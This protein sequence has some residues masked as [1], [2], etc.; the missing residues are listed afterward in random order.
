M[1]DACDHPIPPPPGV[2][3]ADTFISSA[4]AEALNHKGN[5]VSY[6]C[7]PGSTVPV[8]KVFTKSEALASIIP[9]NE[10]NSIQSQGLRTKLLWTFFAS[11]YAEMV[12]TLQNEKY[13][14]VHLHTSAPLLEFSFLSL[15]DIPALITIHAS[16]GTLYENRVLES[17][18]KRDSIY[19]TSI[20]HYQEK[21]YSSLKFLRRIQHGI[22]LSEFP[23]NPQ[24][25]TDLL[26]AGRLK[27]IKGISEAVTTALALKQKLHIVGAVSYDDIPF[28]NAEIKPQI[29][30]HSD[31]LL[32]HGHKSRSEMNIFFGNA[33]LYLMPML[34]EEA[35]G[36]VLIESMACG[37][38]VVAF[39]RGSAQ[40]IVIDGKTGFLINPSDNDI[41]GNFIIKETGV[42]GLQEAVRRIN[43]LSQEDYLQ[44]RQN[45]RNHVE[46]YFTFDRMVEEYEE[47][48]KT[49]TSG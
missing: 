38:P 15:V 4:L 8:K 25:G 13:D 21:V 32:F 39:A 47:A 18:P 45:C 16:D 41:R 14:L 40:E 20:S 27:K 35:F 23:F 33:R 12:K 6:L 17:L 46:K 28:F 36:L 5:D 22:H 10:Y 37:T 2:I 34:W 11:T 24:G 43:T 9:L 29:D 30:E 42:E 49:I 26:F 44:M 3:R 31:M 19:F 48:Y 1:V 7:H